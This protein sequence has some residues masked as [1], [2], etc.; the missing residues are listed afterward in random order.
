MSRSKAVPISLAVE[1]GDDGCASAELLALMVLG[2]SMLP[3][4]TEGEIVV[5]EPDGLAQDG[6]YVLAQADGELILRQLRRGAA[7][8]LLHPLNAA[9]PDQS[10]VDLGA[11]RGVV[12]QKS[13]PGRR[14]SLKRY[15]D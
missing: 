6:A 8:W 11:V 2:D 7:G 9:Y 14:R 3:E 15:V 13:W 12:I 4:F 10:I 1:A 5:I